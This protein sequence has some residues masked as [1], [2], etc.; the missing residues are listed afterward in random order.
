MVPDV[1]EGADIGV[2]ESGHSA[3]FLFETLAKIDILGKAFG[4]DLDGDDAPQATVASAIHFA[5]PACA[6]RRLN[7]IRTKFRAGSESHSCARLYPTHHFQPDSTIRR[8]GSRQGWA[9]RPRASPGMIPL[10]VSLDADK[11]HT[12]ASGGRGPADDWTV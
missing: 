12:G 9:L 3:R 2:G 1:V 5:H 6:K 11:E 8:S 4:Q 10:L 7:F